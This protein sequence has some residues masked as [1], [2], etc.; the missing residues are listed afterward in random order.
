[1]KPKVG[2][3][4]KDERWTSFYAIGVVVRVE[5]EYFIGM[6]M[7]ISKNGFEP[8]PPLLDERTWH[9]NEKGLVWLE[10]LIPTGPCFLLSKLI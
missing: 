5:G 7:R 8:V 4:Y 2:D 3:V 6:E 9:T 10:A 1:M